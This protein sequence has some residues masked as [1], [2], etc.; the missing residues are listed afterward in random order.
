MARAISNMKPGVWPAEPI[1]P[2][3]PFKWQTRRVVKPQPP[4]TTCQLIVEYGK[5]KE[6][7]RGDCWVWD[8]KTIGKPRHNIGDI[9]WARE[10]W[11]I[12]K[13]VDNGQEEY[14]YK[15]SCRVLGEDV[16]SWKPSIFMPRKAARLFLEVKGV[17]IERV[18]DITP[19]D[20]E[21]E[22]V[23]VTGYDLGPYAKTGDYYTWAYQCLWHDINGKKHPWDSNPY[24][25]VYEF[26]RVK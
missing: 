13:R 5:L 20:A 23:D 18:Q 3:E 11:G 15:A 10:A 26:M 12:A 19:E 25:Y 21:A 2:S 22:G 14:V 7:W 6:I 4:D 24:V 17:R 9:L 8:S 1:N 16:P